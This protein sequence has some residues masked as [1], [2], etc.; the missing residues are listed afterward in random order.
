MKE[1]FI[2]SS[3]ILIIGGVITK[4][5]GMLNKIVMTRLLTEEGVGIYMLIVPTFSLF[6]N[7][8]S[9]GFPVAV[10]KMI[11]ENNKKSIKL[12]SSTIV[13][14]LF[15]NILLII[16][17]ILVAPF[18]SH[19]LLKEDRCIYG[20]LAI[21]FVIPF[22]SISSIIRSYFFGKEKTFPHV[23]SNIIEDITRL[24]LIIIGIPIYIRKG[25]EYAVF[26]LIASNVLCEIV[27]IITL[28][29]FVPKNKKI[30]KNDIKPSKTYLKDSLN[31]SIPTTINRLIGSITYFLEPIILTSCLLYT[32]FSN[33]YIISEYGV[34]QAY[35]MPTLLLP[36]FFSM[37]ISQALLP[38]IS[39]NY[40]L[41]KYRYT[42]KKIKEACLLCF[43]LGLVFTIIFIICPNIILNLL[44]N[45]NRGSLYM[46]FLAPIVLLQY[47]ISPIQ[48]SLDAMGK[49][50][51]NLIITIITSIIRTILIPIL[52]L[53][54]IGI[55]TL[56]IS[57]SINVIIGSLL[58]IKVINNSLK[59]N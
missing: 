47:I 32:G 39:K 55:W 29:L 44:Y 13:A 40:S 3:I 58:S 31:I 43:L 22:T 41:K 42:K 17:I 34:L 51:E 25:L 24:L 38:I 23:L 54:K 4:L 15:I 10:S 26:Y 33:K 46:R 50:N 36:S 6:V 14:S 1:K 19:S 18:L 45:T 16:I 11:A 12:L 52:S 2:K 20:I 21:S 49:S 59:Q 30:T 48:T 8:A 57:I 37:S 56:I 5:L 27:S 35:V 53:F 9:F 28:L 7:I